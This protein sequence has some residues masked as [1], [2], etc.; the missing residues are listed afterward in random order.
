MIVS[1]EE[2][3]QY[4]RVDYDEDDELLGQLLLA[5]EERCRKISRNDNFADDPNAPVAIMF[6]VAYLYEHREEADNNALNISLRALLFSNRE[7]K[8]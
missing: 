4:L 2:I 1:L 8:F 7:V 3:K 5:A 6:T